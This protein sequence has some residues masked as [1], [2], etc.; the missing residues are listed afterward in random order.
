MSAATLTLPAGQTRQNAAIQLLVQLYIA[1]HK[2][3]LQISEGSE[4]SA[5]KILE[6]R[7][8]AELATLSLSL[9]PFLFY[10]FCTSYLVLQQLSLSSLSAPSS[11]TFFDILHN[12]L[13]ST[14]Q[15]NEALSTS[16][17][18]AEDKKAVEHWIQA[19]TTPSEEQ[20]DVKSLDEVLKAKTYIAGNTLTAADVA[21]FANLHPYIVRLRPHP[22]LDYS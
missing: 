20:V 18:S 4:V 12:L 8:K 21:V 6:S 14:G 3:D 5:R 9:R 11:P 13:E 16:T 19:A 17:S 15:T 1:P 7:S 22:D 10:A 2:P